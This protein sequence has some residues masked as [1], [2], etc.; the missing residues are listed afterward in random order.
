MM[1]SKA[2]KY[3][4]EGFVTRTQA[5]EQLPLTQFHRAT[6]ACQ[7][8]PGLIERFRGKIV[9]DI[10]SDRTTTQRLRQMASAAA[11]QVEN[12]KRARC[13]TVSKK[14]LHASIDLVVK[15]IVTVKDFLIDRPRIKK[16]FFGGLR[17]GFSLFICS[18][19]NLAV[20]G[21]CQIP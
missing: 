2:G 5:L 11:S 4:V 17:H 18:L 7:I 6:Q 3:K 12:G 16:I 15:H 9:A 13:E 14:A 10:G 19:K 1:E 20:S 8:T 21:F